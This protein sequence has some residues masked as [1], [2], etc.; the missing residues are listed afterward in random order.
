MYPQVLR[1]SQQ[2]LFTVQ[3]LQTENAYNLIALLFISVR[4]TL[5]WSQLNSDS[6]NSPPIHPSIPPPSRNIVHQQL[7]KAE[8]LLL[9][10]LPSPPVG[11]TSIHMQMLPNPPLVFFFFKDG[12]FCLVSLLPQI[13]H[14]SVFM[15][16]SSETNRR[17]NCREIGI[18][19][20]V[21]GPGLLWLYKWW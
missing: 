17:L 6:T 9:L 11:A 5:Q 8:L 1:G 3:P 10:L 14:S 19:V 2:C 18:M 15:S 12:S 7:R 20:P 21:I 4:K 16:S 13:P